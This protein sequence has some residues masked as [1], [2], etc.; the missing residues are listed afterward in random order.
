MKRLSVRGVELHVLVRGTGLP[1]VFAHAF[2][3]DH[4]MWSAQIERFAGQAQVIAPDLR[5]FGSSGVTPGT[6]TMEQM[7]DDLAEVL[8][9][10]GVTEPIVLCGCSMGGYAAFQFARKY[11]G[12]LRGLVLCNTRFAADSPR[13]ARGDRI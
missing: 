12:R 11:P 3:L 8:D 7:A 10:L 4:S 13:L 5:G 9:Q 6:V 1:L 2:P